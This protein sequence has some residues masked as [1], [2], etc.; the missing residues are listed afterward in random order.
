MAQLPLFEE[1]AVSGVD[2]EATGIIIC[3]T[4]CCFA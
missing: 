2:L 3:N 4:A 1:V